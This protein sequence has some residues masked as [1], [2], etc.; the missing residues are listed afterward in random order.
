MANAR[1]RQAARLALERLEGREVPAATPWQVESFEQ[2]AAGALPSGWAQHNSDPL[3]VVQATTAVAQASAVGLGMSG[4]SVSESR[5]WLNAA[6]PAD[7]QVTAS[8]YLDSLIPAQI[9]ARGQNLDTDTPTYYAVSVTRGLQLQLRSVVNGQ[10]TVL[11]TLQSNS[12]ISGQWV[13]VS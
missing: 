8:V 9:I 1:R 5:A 3:A 7:A 12:W 10:A 13:R 4:S 2:A 6:L 11:Q